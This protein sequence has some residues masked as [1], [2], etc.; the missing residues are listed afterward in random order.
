M[1]F[2]MMIANQTLVLRRRKDTTMALNKMLTSHPEY[3]I[4]VDVR[5]DVTRGRRQGGIKPGTHVTT[6]QGTGELGCRDG[7]GEDARGA[8]AA[9]T[10]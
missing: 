1:T 9:E 4:R 2:R 3:D 6:S 10:R 7:C 8:A 5:R